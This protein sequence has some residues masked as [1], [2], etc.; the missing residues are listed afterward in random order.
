MAKK[1]VRNSPSSSNKLN[2]ANMTDDFQLY[3]DSSDDDAAPEELTFEESK[4]SALRS[5]KNA[6]E[7]SKREK[8]FLKE[9]RRKRQELFQEQKK[10]RLLPAHIL[11]EIDT[12][13]SK[14][15]KLPGDQAESNNEE[16]SCL[17]EEGS[18]GSKEGYE[19]EPKKRLKG[20]IRSLK[21][22]YMVMRV[23]DQSSNN[24]QQQTAKDF[25]QARLYG[26]GSRRTTNN[27]LLSLQNKRGPNKSAAMQFVNKKWGTE[28]KAKAEKL[29]KQWIHKQKVPSS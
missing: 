1:L 29:K 20:N 3:L 18:E 28:K 5:M 8:D 9:K 13:P 15:Q 26:P 2:S 24:S 12:A 10:R 11:E 22:N 23:A 27:E 25:I 4:A 21:G 17:R 7:T 6:L 16:A 19:K 14:K